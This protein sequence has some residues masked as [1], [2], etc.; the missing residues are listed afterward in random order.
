[1][2]TLT[3]SSA[4]RMA[5]ALAGAGAL[6][7]PLAGCGSSSSSS[8]S[9]KSATAAGSSTSSTP[10]KP[11]SPKQ[12]YA[13]KAGVVCQQLSEEIRTVG[14]N[15]KPLKQKGEELVVQRERAN[16]RLKALPVPSGDKLA[17]EWIRARQHAVALERKVVAQ[18]EPFSHANA[19]LNAEYSAA[20][21]AASQLGAN[22]R[23]VG[24][25]G[26]GAA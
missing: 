14:T 25:K 20:F 1:V 4:L 21:I 8:S 12:Q 24:C 10:A 7:V 15:G 16:E 6:V 19:K 22:D 11:Q 13:T 5:A 26:L 2:Q 3:R 17:V 23:I 18:K 9:T